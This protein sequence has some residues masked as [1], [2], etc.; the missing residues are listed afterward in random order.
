M[1]CQKQVIQ[2]EVKKPSDIVKV[3]GTIKVAVLENCSPLADAPLVACSVYDQKGVHFLSTCVE[4]VKWIEKKRE[5]FDK[6]SCSIKTGSF[7]RLS[8]NDSY[9]MNMNNVDIA[10]QLCGNYR[11]DGKWMQKMKWWWAIYFWQYGTMIV[12]AFICYKRF[13]EMEGRKPLSHYEFQKRLILAKIAPQEFGADKQHWSIA[14][15][16][17]D[18]RSCGRKHGSKRGGDNGSASTRSTRSSTTES[19]SKKQKTASPPVKA[20]YAMV[21]KFHN[22]KSEFNAKRLD[23]GVCHLPEN[24]IRQS[25]SGQC[26]SLCRWATGRKCSS[27]LLKCRDCNVLLCSWCYSLFHTVAYLDNIY[28]KKLGEEIIERKKMNR[29]VKR[30][31]KPCKRKN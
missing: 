15:Q 20:E 6:T 5:V 29:K 1:A 12:N 11:P 13:M 16:Q 18:H 26:C 9:N 22:T 23:L 17:E 2:H 24:S 25:T 27:Q 21:G 14:F 4:Q 19:S 3:K 28:K 30:R 31:G 7:L 10:D 8:V